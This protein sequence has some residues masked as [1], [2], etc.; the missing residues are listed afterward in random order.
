MDAIWAHPAAHPAERA[1]HRIFQPEEEERRSQELTRASVMG[2]DEARLAVYFNAPLRDPSLAAQAAGAGAVAAR[3]AALEERR[4]AFSAERTRAVAE[5]PDG[6]AILDVRIG[7]TY[8]AATGM[9]TSVFVEVGA[10]NRYDCRGFLYDA[11]FAG[12]GVPG[13]TRTFQCITQAQRETYGAR[14]HDFY[15]RGNS[16][17]WRARVCRPPGRRH[18]ARDLGT[19]GVDLAPWHGVAWEPE[20]MPGP[21]RDGQGPF[22]GEDA[23]RFTSS[24]MTSRAPSGTAPESLERDFEAMNLTTLSTDRRYQYVQINLRVGRRVEGTRTHT[25]IH[26]LCRSGDGSGGDSRHQI[27]RRGARAGREE[28]ERRYEA[29]QVQAERRRQAAEIDARVDAQFR[30]QLRNDKRLQARVKAEEEKKA[31]EEREARRMRAAAA[32]AKARGEAV[33]AKRAEARAAAAGEQQPQQQPEGA[34]AEAPGEA[35]R[36]IRPPVPRFPR[37]APKRDGVPEYTRW[38]YATQDRMRGNGRLGTVID[39]VPWGGGLR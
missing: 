33:R 12:L 19:V 38:Y 27:V 23:V 17:P 26:R 11:T 24:S 31:K 10:T 3:G 9:I 5:A 8:D 7:N 14:T 2:H 37:P 34:Q 32:A 36:N 28:A 16:G 30:E 6:S 13:Q 35:L 39:G 4:A 15:L 22:D 18:G 21:Y 1:A 20:P 25:F 29:Q